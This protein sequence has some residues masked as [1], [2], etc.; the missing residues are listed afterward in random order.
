MYAAIGIVSP[1]T[2]RK[3]KSNYVIGV[4]SEVEHGAQVLAASLV[5]QA[6]WTTPAIAT[7]RIFLAFW[8]IFCIALAATYRGNLTAFLLV[9]KDVVPFN[10][11]Q[12]LANQNVYKW[13]VI[14]STVVEGLLYTSQREDF[15]K[16]GDGLKKFKAIDPEVVSLDSEVHRRKINRG[17][18]AYISDMV[19]MEI[20]VAEDCDLRFLKETVMP[21]PFVVGLHNNSVYV[22][23]FN[24]ILLEIEQAGLYQ[25]WKKKWWPSGGQC[26]TGTQHGTK[27]VSL[28]Q[29]QSAFY[30][31][32]IGLVT[33]I[34]LLLLE[35][36]WNRKCAALDL[37][38]SS[39][40]NNSDNSQGESNPDDLYEKKTDLDTLSS[41]LKLKGSKPTQSHGGFDWT[42]DAKWS[43]YVTQFL[44]ED[45]ATFSRREWPTADMWD[46]ERADERSYEGWRTLDTGL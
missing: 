30:V 7:R 22:Q 11:L 28:L 44:T 29:S 17:Q 15:R 41:T 18:Y 46:T 37:D 10:T 2:V 43:N 12:E 40:K 1:L 36:C 9:Y 8:W 39:Q 4:L 34:L 24:G 19:P 45:V 5:H 23:T 42:K 35:T 33:S 26:I 32:L 25:M 16:L 20:W 38:N 6:Q 31:L 13:G 3:R 21:L 27:V 14:G